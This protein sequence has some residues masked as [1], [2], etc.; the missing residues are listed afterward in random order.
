MEKTGQMQ[1]LFGK[2][3]KRDV[4]AISII[5]RWVSDVFNLAE[6]DII[7]VTELQCHEEG[8]PPFETV[9]V[10]LMEG[11]RKVQYKFHKRINEVAF[12]DISNL[13]TQ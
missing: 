13:L 8:C 7:L 5:K 4:A 6:N 3:Q 12:E 9:I 10:I 11:N 2:N 1:D